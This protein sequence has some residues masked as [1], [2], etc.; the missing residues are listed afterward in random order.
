[1]Y[2]YDYS[3]GALVPFYLI[4][5]KTLNLEEKMFLTQLR[6]RLIFLCNFCFETFLSSVNIWR[7]MLEMGAEMHVHLHVNCQLFLSDFN[8]NLSGS[9]NLN[10][11]SKH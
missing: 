6:M 10:K 4:I 3:C 7:V 8:Q 1:M 2:A 11:I 5:W 9:T